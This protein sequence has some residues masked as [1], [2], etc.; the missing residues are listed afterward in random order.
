VKLGPATAEDLPTA[1]STNGKRKLR[2]LQDDDRTEPPAIP[3]SGK[4][5]A[6]GSLPP[7]VSQKHPVS[8]QNAIYAAERLSC[9]LEI[10]HSINFILLGE[11]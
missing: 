7:G 10:T 11:I 5:A 4:D 1:M 6:E 8:I 3:S 2:E 9:S